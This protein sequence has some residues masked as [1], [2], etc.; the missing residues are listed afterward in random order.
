MRGPTLLLQ[1]ERESDGLVFDDND[2]AL[3]SSLTKYGRIGTSA[4]TS[5]PSLR[6][7]EVVPLIMN[8]LQNNNKPDKDAGLR[9]VWDFSTDI[10]KHIFKHNITG[11]KKI[12]VAHISCT[13]C[14]L[15]ILVCLMLS[16]RRI[17]R[18]MSRN[19]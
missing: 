3:F 6:P 16:V 14:L 4:D 8:S 12:C 15:R 9:L 7:E 17:H 10:T 19:C 5:D 18:I 2:E 11:K 1:E 13:F